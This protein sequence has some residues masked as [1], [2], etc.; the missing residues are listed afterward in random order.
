MAFHGIQGNIMDPFS[1]FNG[2]TQ[3]VKKF[4]HHKITAALDNQTGFFACFYPGNKGI[5]SPF[6]FDRL[7]SRIKLDKKKTA[8]LSHLNE[9]GTV[10]YVSKYKSHI[11]F[12]FYRTIFEK[13]ALPYPE[14]IFDTAFFFL[15]PVKRLFKIF[16]TQIDSLICTFSFKD[17]YV[18]RYFFG[19]F[20]KGRS[21][22]IHLVESKSFYKRFIRS[23][24]SPL[25]HLIHFQKSSDRP[26]LLV[27]QTII[28]SLKPIRTTSSLFDILL[29]SN[30]KPGRLKRL[31]AMFQKPDK[32]CIEISDPINLKEFL[33]RPDIKNIDED[34]QAYSLRTHLMDLLNRQ[35]QSFTGPV[36][37]TRAEITED[38]LTQ[39]TLQEFM[40]AHSE[41]N[42]TPLMTTHK[43]AASYIKEIAASYS[44]PVIYIL[45]KI[46]TWAFN[47]IFE[48]V[49]V[50][51]DGL[52]RIRE[53]S[54]K[55]PVILAPC[56]KS[57]L[58]YLLLS[59]LMF[60]NNMPCPHIAAGKNLS[61]WPLGPIFRS[62]GAFFLRRTFKGAPLYSRI[63]G[64]YV[65]KLLSEG[66]N[67]EFFIEGGRSRT[68]KLLSPKLGLLSML[69][70]AHRNKA[71]EDLIFIPAYVGY[72]RVLEEDAYLHEIE[73]GKKESENLSQ[74]IKA[75]KFLKRKYGK[76]Y[77][78]FHEPISLNAYLRDKDEFQRFMGED[79]HKKLCQSMGYKLINAI[80]NTTII[81][82]HGIIASGILNS[83]AGRFSKKELMFRV[84][85]YMNMLTFCNAE[86][87]DTLTIDPDRALDRVLQNFVSRKFIEL[88]D[89]EEDEITE[90][91]RFF[92][93][94]NKRP[95]L[96]YYK[97]NAIA[98][99]IPA[100]YT[101]LAI[102]KTDRFQFSSTDLHKTYGFL[103]DFF[104]DEFS[105]DDEKTCSE[106]IS[107]SIKAFMEEGVVVPHPE[108]SDTFNLTSE[109]FRQLRSFSV[110]LKPFMESYKVA[111]LYFEKYPAGK[112]DAKERI[113][114]IQA[115]GLKMYKRQDILL[116]ES[117]SNINYTN[118]TTFFMNNGVNGTE[119]NDAIV[120]YKKIIEDFL[121][122][123]TV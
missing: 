61:F 78:K 111:L 10:I 57:H 31:A 93:K 75:R 99:F 9:T 95:V 30:E 33:N 76:V 107:D 74:L 8:K 49:V 53:E 56:H 97:N 104:I 37:K 11:D 39:K 15:L 25:L 94:D 62:G 14:I 23:K 85:A 36:L 18:S 117:L 34:F 32:I 52:D 70:K 118:A 54:K 13:N 96:D 116:K 121:V 5:L 50:D 86:L 28:Y 81:T 103:Q 109:G 29:G 43:K 44:L 27:P 120:K 114:K 12:L 88:A 108:F 24:P 80:N 84:S 21:G 7:F 90:N 72:D 41:Q 89:D 40:K 16:I 60:K 92:V 83:P 79:Q 38:I 82:P 87:A 65:E 42:E 66:F 63:F 58:D 69:I 101:A 46:L 91:T 113:K 115:K 20:S 67:M 2:T 48:G 4:Y 3:A 106:H 112:H 119:D 68:G 45:E 55:A 19:E 71:C 1:I 122:I 123:L 35:K 22:F 47:N 102:L 51:Q 26:L 110:F 17:P 105:F 64:A 100:A 6:F 59:Y 98:F 77:I 73:G